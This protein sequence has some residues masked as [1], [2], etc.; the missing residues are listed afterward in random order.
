[1][2]RSWIV[3]IVAA[4]MLSFGSIGVTAQD[5][6]KLTV[7]A[8]ASLTDAFGVIADQFKAEH[9]G[10]DIVFNFAGSSDLAA[11][12]AEG[13]PADVFAS[14]NTKQMQVAQDAGRIGS[15]P[16]AFVKNRLVLIT[17]AENPAGIHTL[18][19]L[20][21]TGVKLVIA[22]AGVPVRDYTDTLLTRLAADAGYGEAY[23]TAVMA[24]VV[25]EEPN[26][27][28][29]SAKVAL[30]EADAG[31]VYFSD[32]TPDIKDS[33]QI[34]QIPDYLNT[35]ATYPIAIT[36][37][38]A[39]AP[40]AQAFVDYVLSDAGQD[41]LV[42]WNFISIRIPEVPTTITLSE[43]TSSFTVDGQVLN[44][45]T[46]TAEDLKANFT[47][48]TLDVTY[49]SGE[50]STSASFTGVPL[51]QVINAAQPN[52]NADVKNDK[53]SMFITV[54][55]SDGYQAVIAWG[56]ID[57]DFAS[58]PILVAYEQDG[59]ALEGSSLRLIVPTDG[60]GGRYVSGVIN[61]TLHDAPHVAK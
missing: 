54:T 4:L 41:T 58:Q 11:Q 19:D 50:E 6:P 7:F 27:R 49:L 45:L 39:D 16:K 56:E 9:E 35:I 51:W 3:L 29:V 22:G 1:M 12:L 57:P 20:G 33:V 8:A 26:V 40:L 34:I 60:H 13:A 48:Q 47:S 53:L 25:S 30:G 10:V 42:A 28:Q 24:N 5:T 14:A 61:I 43:D 46:L 52:F 15:K 31:F 59:A 21:N 32:V 44:P 37:N 23:Q 2:K 38:A 17:P 55:G 36:D 18:H